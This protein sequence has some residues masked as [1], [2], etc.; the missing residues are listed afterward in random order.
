MLD[1][2]IRSV[3]P[4]GEMP[5]IWLFRDSFKGFCAASAS[6]GSFLAGLE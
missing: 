3:F 2:P 4:K 5:Q 1:N 6:C